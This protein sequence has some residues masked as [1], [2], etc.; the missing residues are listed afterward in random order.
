M[1]N[2]MEKK[3]KESKEAIKERISKLR[4]AKKE[5][6]LIKVEVWIKSEDKEKVKAFDMSN[7]IDKKV[8]GR[9]KKDK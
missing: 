7:T 6:G 4:Q 1:V 5:A 2:I 8:S 9:P 3:R